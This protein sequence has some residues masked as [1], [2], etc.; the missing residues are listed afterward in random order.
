[1]SDEGPEYR[2][3]EKLFLTQLENLDWDVTDLGPS[4]PQDPATSK[5]LPQ[6][7]KG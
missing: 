2:E 3:V 1:M 4:I 5:Y 7:S 6:M